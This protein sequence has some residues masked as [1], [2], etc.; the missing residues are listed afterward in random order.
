MTLCN[1]DRKILTTAIC[2]GLQWCT[3]RCFH[4]SQRCIS[5]RQMTYNIFDVETTALA[6]VACAPHESGILLTDFA[7]AYPS[8]NHSWIFHVLEKAELPECIC[9]FFLMIYCNSTT[10]IEFAG[11]TEDNSS[12]PGVCG[13]AVLRAA[14]CLQWRSIPSFICLQDAIIPRNPAAPD[15][16]Q[17]VPCAYADDFAVAA[18][19]FRCLMTAL[20]PTF[21]FTRC[22]TTSGQ[23]RA[24]GW[25]APCS[26][27]NPSNQVTQKSSQEQMT[28]SMPCQKTGRLADVWYLDDGNILY[29]PA[30][31]VPNLAAFDTASSQICATEID[32]RQKSSTTSQIQ[33]TLLVTGESAK[34]SDHRRHGSAQGCCLTTTLHR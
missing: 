2:R 16:F 33:T 18:S 12:W 14:S 11:R 26:G 27:S 9:Q 13:K 30:L 3:M 10:H 22:K 5:A 19:S 20:D 25:R 24:V 29:H 23:N 1:C 34:H 15:L 8:V 21:P 4:P 7:A 31:V 6:H 28:P 32:K 17:S